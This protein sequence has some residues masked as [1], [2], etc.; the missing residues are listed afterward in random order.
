MNVLQVK[1]LRP[2]LDTKSVAPHRVKVRSTCDEADVAAALRQQRTKV[3]AKASRSHD[4]HAHRRVSNH[5]VLRP[6]A[7]S[8]DRPERN[9][10]LHPTARLPP[11]AV[12]HLSCSGRAPQR[13][14]TASSITPK[15]VTLAA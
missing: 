5:A 11:S 7:M 2:A 12:T 15:G 10:C 8:D 14:P 13:S 1:R 6:Q 9:T 3:A 4:R